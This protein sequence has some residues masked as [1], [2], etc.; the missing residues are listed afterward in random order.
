MKTL[1][2]RNIHPEKW[3]PTGRDLAHIHKYLSETVVAL[4]E[5]VGNDKCTVDAAKLLYDFCTQPFE[6]VKPAITQHFIDCYYSVNGDIE[7]CYRDDEL[8]RLLYIVLC[9]DRL[10][11]K[12][13]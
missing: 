10:P 3:R 8:L 5:E 7:C 12:G 1:I 4:A 9:P 2:I 6:K 11:T 13:A